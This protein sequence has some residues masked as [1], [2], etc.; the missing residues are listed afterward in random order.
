M[1]LAEAIKAGYERTDL[2]SAPW[3]GRSVKEMAQ[4]I[5]RRK[6]EKPGVFAE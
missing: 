3:D 5:A 1:T 4:D 2:R 6:V